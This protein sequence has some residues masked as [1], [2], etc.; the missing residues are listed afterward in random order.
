MRGVGTGQEGERAARGVLGKPRNRG[1][2]V[3]KIARLNFRGEF[4]D[5]APWRLGLRSV[6]AQYGRAEHGRGDPGRSPTPR[7]RSSWPSM[8]G[9]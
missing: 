2:E 5:L 3:A 9:S 8:P 6:G 7:L 4:H 1:V